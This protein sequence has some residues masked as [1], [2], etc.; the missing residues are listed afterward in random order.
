MPKEETPTKKLEVV[1]EE[2][3]T[4]LMHGSDKIMVVM[5]SLA[6]LSQIVG[7]HF[8]FHKDMDSIYRDSSWFKVEDCL[9]RGTRKNTSKKYL[10]RYLPFGRQSTNWKQDMG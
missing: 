2:K 10:A 6:L 3:L 7:L 9:I 5:P 4:P 1:S 8:I